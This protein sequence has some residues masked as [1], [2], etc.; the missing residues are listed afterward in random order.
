MSEITPTAKSLLTWLGFESDDDVYDAELMRTRFGYHS[1]TQRTFKQL[2]S[3]FGNLESCERQVDAELVRLTEAI[4]RVIKT[5]EA[6]GGVDTT[7]ITQH[8]QRLEEARRHVAETVEK[9]STIAYILV[10]SRP[11]K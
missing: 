7:W 6:D 9:I 10:G 5:R 3:L 8:T 4:Q 11:E 1:A 2:P